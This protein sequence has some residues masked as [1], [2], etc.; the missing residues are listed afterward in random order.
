MC[1]QLSKW[2][3]EV[4][5]LATVD[6]LVCAAGF[7]STGNVGCDSNAGILP[8]MKKVT[9]SSNMSSTLRFGSDS[10]EG[11]KKK[12]QVK[13]SQKQNKTKQNNQP[14]KE[15]PEFQENSES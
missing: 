11:Q 6:A 4:L 8:A 3:S 1:P 13:L 2:V 9:K 15:L 14:Q 10:G 5:N 12:E 7:T